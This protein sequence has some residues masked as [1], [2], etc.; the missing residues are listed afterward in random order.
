ME[1]VQRLRNYAEA[2]LYQNEAELIMVTDAADEIERLRKENVEMR[3]AL[4]DISYA[5]DSWRS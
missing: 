4:I 1:I 5:V 3:E 2:R